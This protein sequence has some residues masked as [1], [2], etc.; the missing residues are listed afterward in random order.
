[1]KRSERHSLHSING[2][3]STKKGG[4]STVQSISR[5]TSILRCIL[6][7]FHSIKDISAHCDLSKS[8]VHRLLNSL[9]KSDFIYQNPV[10]H[11]YYLGSLFN[12][13]SIKQP[14]AHQKF[15]AQSWDEIHRIWDMFG[16]LTI[17]DI[18]VGL[19]KVNLVALTS[20]FNYSFRITKEDS[21]LFYGSNAKVL[22]AQHDNEE[23][24]V[25]LNNIT[26]R[27]PS[28]DCVTDKAELKKQLQTAR[29]QGYY[30]SREF[31]DGMMGISVSITTYLCPAAL[32]VAGPES[33]LSPIASRVVEELKVSAKL[34]EDKITIKK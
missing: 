9:E 3:K 23:I 5:A 32:S 12:R 28:S 15:L 13:L 2:G 31:G 6:D 25:T 14:I 17:L 21:L 34:I 10:N 29:N 1:M 22:F 7:G 11:Q 24:D 8:T 26:P 18:H 4:D 16:E 33:R 19:L 30:I 27:P 20:K